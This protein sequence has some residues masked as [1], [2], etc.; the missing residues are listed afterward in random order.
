M[1]SGQIK[2]V[3]YDEKSDWLPRRR[4]L[5]LQKRK[6]THHWQVTK[7]R[8]QYNVKPKRQNEPNVNF[9]FYRIEPNAFV[10]ENW[11]TRSKLDIVTAP[12][13]LKALVT[14]LT[15][16]L[17][18]NEA[19][20]SEVLWSR[21]ES[22]DDKN[23][24]LTRLINPLRGFRENIEARISHHDWFLSLLLNKKTNWKH[25]INSQLPFVRTIRHHQRFDRWNPHQVASFK[26]STILD[27]FNWFRTRMAY[28]STNILKNK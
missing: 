13:P 8:C 14:D 27:N 16:D 9:T 7:N 20:L 28:R 21:L 26:Q 6:Q 11:S 23:F 25:L 4:I 10:A 15:A 12:W 17:Y 1:I 22:S 24:A 2:T 5:Q 19:D 3:L 18:S